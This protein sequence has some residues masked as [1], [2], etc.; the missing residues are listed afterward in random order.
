MRVSAP[1]ECTRNRQFYTAGN[2]YGTCEPCKSGTWS[3]GN[4]NSC[5]PLVVKV[6]ATDGGSLTPGVNSGDQILVAFGEETNT[7]YTSVASLVSG[8]GA[9]ECGYLK[10]FRAGSVSSQDLIKL[11]HFERVGEGGLYESIAINN[12]EVEGTWTSKTLL[13]ITIKNGTADLIT[14]LEHLGESHISMN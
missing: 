4:A 12:Y 5:F 1:L 7:P 11:L 10:W 14:V 9:G 2:N 8:I 3:D 13:T 6:V